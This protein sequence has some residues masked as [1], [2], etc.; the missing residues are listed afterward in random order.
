MAVL[1]TFRES[2]LGRHVRQEFMR[3]A[4]LDFTP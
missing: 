1:W 2:T 4:W 3:N